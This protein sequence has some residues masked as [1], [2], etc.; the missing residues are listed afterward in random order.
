MTTSLPKETTAHLFELF[1]QKWSKRKASTSLLWVLVG[2][3]KSEISLII[4]FG[5]LTI[6]LQ[7]ASFLIMASIIEALI[8]FE[9]GSFSLG[10]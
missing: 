5:F 3:L 10:L 6:S 4:I 2:M 9:P 1:R 7:A 8:S